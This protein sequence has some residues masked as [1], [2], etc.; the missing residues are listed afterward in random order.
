MCPGGCLPR[1]VSAWGRSCL[2]SGCA[3]AGGSLHGGVAYGKS[4][5]KYKCKESIIIA[6]H[7]SPDKEIF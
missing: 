7:L 1:G 4:R 5:H 2:P 3:Q 6:L